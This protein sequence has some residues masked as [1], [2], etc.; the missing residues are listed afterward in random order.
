MSKPVLIVGV[1]G[2]AAAMSARKMGYEPWVVDCIGSRDLQRVAHTLHVLMRD[3]PSKLP[4]MVEK[5]PKSA[6][7]MMSGDLEN[8][9][10]IWEAIT[11]GR[12]VMGSSAAAVRSVRAAGSLSE[13]EL[14]K[15]LKHCKIK[16]EGGLLQRIAVQVFGNWDRRKYLLKPMSGS[17][18][19]GIRFWEKGAPIGREYYLQEYVAG[20]P[21][22]VMFRADGWSVQYVGACEMIVGD[23]AFGSDGF[24][25][26]G[27]I[28]EIDL[29]EEARAGVSQLAVAMT[30]R[31]DLRGVF[32]IDFV[33]DFS[34]KLR[35]LE[36]NPRYTAGMEVLEMCTGQSVFDELSSS[37][38]KRKEGEA[39]HLKWGKAL[40]RAKIDCEM[41]DLFGVLGER[42]IA[43][44]PNVG[45]RVS[46]G[47][48]ICSVFA[49]GRTRDEVYDGLKE[50]A[51]KIYDAVLPIK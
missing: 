44:V 24:K 3:Y 40:I 45:V 21:I 33:M 36:I 23:E 27:S 1:N 47:E 34:G 42:W 39:T 8:Y 10:D 7:V 5:A 29:S 51:K 22:G 12:E 15:G 49:D 14:A 11:F 50:K 13:V 26:V 46:Q 20:M 9:P 38:K 25:Y 43:N 32:G 2:R 16:T 30:Q 37:S 28:G 35:P 41:P 17:G 31:H 48:P 4:G 18:G 6:A 19:M